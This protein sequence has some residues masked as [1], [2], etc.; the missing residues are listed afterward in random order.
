MVMIATQNQPQ[1]ADTGPPLL[2]AMPKEP[3]CTQA[4]LGQASRN[5]MQPGRLSEDFTLHQAMIGIG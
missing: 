1:I 2:Y 3:A 5:R 4:S